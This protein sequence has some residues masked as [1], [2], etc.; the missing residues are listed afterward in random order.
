MKDIIIGDKSIQQEKFFVIPEE[1]IILPSN[2]KEKVSIS[3]SELSK[4]VSV[5]AESGESGYAF[6][7][8]VWD[9]KKKKKEKDKTVKEMTDL[10]EEQKKKL[11]AELTK[12]YG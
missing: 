1:F 12:L 6:I 11:E 8:T 3:K 7:P 2:K 9:A 5:G 4:A 10:L